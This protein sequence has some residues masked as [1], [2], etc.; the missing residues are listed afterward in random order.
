M[1]KRSKLDL[2]A[3]ARSTL[4]LDMEEGLHG[5]IELGKEPDSM[6]SM[7][8]GN[9]IAACSRHMLLPRL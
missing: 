3:A 5:S 9:S 8:Q 1:G 6:D 7:V 2:L 4:E